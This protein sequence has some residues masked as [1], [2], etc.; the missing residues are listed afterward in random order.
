M[1][2]KILFIFLAMLFAVNLNAQTSGWTIQPG[3]TTQNL[4]GIAFSDASTWIAVGDAGT[5]LRSSDG[6]INWT[7]ISSPVTDALR[8]VSMRGNLGVAVGTAGRVVRTTD[9]GLSWTEIPRPTTK[10]LFS[11]SMGN[12]MTV[13]TGEEG[14]ILV[15]TNDGLTWLS[16][17]A[18]TAS[19]LFG[20]SVHETNAVGVGGQGAVVM[21]VNS[22]NGWGLTILG[23]QLTF[24]YSISLVN[25]TTC[26]AVGSSATGNLIIKSTNS[27]FVWTGQTAPTTEQLFGVSFA[28]MDTG[29]A[30]GGNGTIIHTINGGTNWV[31]QSSGTNQ[32][33]NAVSFVNANT[34][35]SV[36]NSGTILRTTN[37]GSIAGIHNIS[38][39]IPMNF[40]V[41]QNYFF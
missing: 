20:V 17:T 16:H 14:T 10:I 24:F 34:G 11:V 23:N 15:S 4:R 7:T 29:T 12:S 33:L 19:I 22:G 35:I 27:G 40:S 5:I 9:G 6:G 37:G 2:I 30:V 25:N 18:G 26:W 8:G 31:S 36:G 21:S 1:K 38:N 13:A 32:I 41:Q 3:P 28:V 39:E